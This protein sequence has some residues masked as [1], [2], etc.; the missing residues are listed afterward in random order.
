[1]WLLW[2]RRL[3]AWWFKEYFD[4]KVE[5]DRYFPYFITN[6]H[7]QPLH[8]MLR[9][10]GSPACN[11]PPPRISL[12]WVVL[13]VHVFVSTWHDVHGIPALGLPFVGRHHSGLDDCKTIVQI[14]QYLLKLGTSLP[15]PLSPE[16]AVSL[17]PLGWMD[18]WAGHVFADPTKIEKDF[19]P[20]EESWNKVRCCLLACACA[21][22]TPRICARHSS[23][24]CHQ[25]T[26]G[27]VGDA[28][29]GTSP[30][31]AITALSVTP[32]SPSD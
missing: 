18:G 22:L 25:E 6:K 1:M 23:T 7:G 19:D 9:G 16:V 31:P 21:W 30:T 20:F 32:P 2:V 15:L 10:K 5:F 12:L 4:L 24:T 26:R 17:T 3:L 27:N 11:P 29:C 13:I 28:H 8:L 14:V